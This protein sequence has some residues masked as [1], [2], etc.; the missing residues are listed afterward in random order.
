MIGL[1]RRRGIPVVFAIH[2]LGY[3]K[4]P[5]LTDVD[6]RIVASEFAR[7]HYR[8]NVGLDCHALPNPVD[9]DRVR[10]EDREPRFVTFVN[11]CRRKGLCRSC[12]SPTSWGGAGRISRFLVV[13][14][15]GTR[16][17]WPPAGWA[18][19]SPCNVQVMP[20]T[21][22]PRR[23]YALTR[24]ALLPSLCPENQ[25]LVA[26]EAMINGIPVIGS[27]RGGIPEALGE[28]G[29]VLPLP[30]RLTPGSRSCRRPRRWSRG[31]R[32]SCGCGTTGRCMR[33]R[34]QGPPGGLALASGSGPAALC[35]VLR[36]CPR[37]SRAR[38]FSSLH[39][40]GRVSLGAAPAPGGSDGAAACL[41]GGVG[42]PAVL[43]VPAGRGSGGRAQSRSGRGRAESGGSR[44]VG[45][46]SLQS[47]LRV[48][49]R[50]P[51]R[52]FAGSRRACLARSPRTKSS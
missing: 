38:R 36:G 44:Q 8:D 40:P 15:R 42:R 20:H 9:W 51:E 39:D 27:D 17:R 14:S 18:G 35:R 10:V 31:S 12:G 21:T 46:Q 29:F 2:N 28:C 5:P 19:T 13:E 24:I 7:R 25:P 43:A 33:S 49:R 52:Q 47:C 32:R 50:D 22:D 11:P 4:A 30:E 45:V 34:A 48:G 23:F 6:A 37:A 26:V 1:A 3:R 16:E 41:R